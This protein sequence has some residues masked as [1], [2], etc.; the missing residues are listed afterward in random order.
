M[1]FG[2]EYV[3]YVFCPVN[4]IDSV[5]FEVTGVS[6][7][8]ALSRAT[9]SGVF[10]GAIYRWITSFW[11]MALT[12]NLCAT[13]TWSRLEPYRRLLL[14]VFPLLLVLLVWRIWQVDRQARKLC[15]HQQSQLGPTLYIILDAGAIYSLT[16]LVALTCFAMQTNGQ[17]VVLDM[18]SPSDIMRVPLN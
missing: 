15:C 5:F 10:G 17:Y 11:I 8:Y 16:L 1:V 14:N 2:C 3:R 13:R 7:S 4:V 9:Q 18:V 12:T 6:S